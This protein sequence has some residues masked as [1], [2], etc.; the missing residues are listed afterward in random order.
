MVRRINLI[1][2]NE[3]QR[4]RTDV[5][6]LV[7]GVAVLGVIGGM[8]FSYFYFS[9]IASDLDTELA[10]LQIQ[11]QQ[12]EAQLSSLSQFEALEQQVAANEAVVQQIYAGRTLVSEV[13]GD[14][15]LVIPQEVWF[16]SLSVTA[17][18]LGGAVDPAV[19]AQP[20][21]APKGAMNAAGLTFTFKDV[22]N[23]LVR[24]EQIPALKDVKLGDAAD[25]GE[26]G[27]EEVK[28]FSVSTSVVNTQPLTASL[29]IT[30]VEVSGP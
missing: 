4:T 25:Q 27:G 12:V 1:P 9:G 22:A 24:L 2:Q 16:E 26:M 5:G 14:L 3:R 7:L 6:L 17:P 10:E 15:S 30:E 8:A 28:T 20:Q 19:A 21:A 29:P 13:L 11:R 18:E 23:L